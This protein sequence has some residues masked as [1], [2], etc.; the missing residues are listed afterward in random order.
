[1]KLD[2]QLFRNY[3]ELYTL[4]L[5]CYKDI[6]ILE[7]YERLQNKK[8]DLY[9]TAPHISN[10]FIV[11]LQKDLALTLWKIY[12]DTDTNA[13]TVPHFRNAINKLLRDSGCKEKQIK[14]GKINKGIVEV[15]KKLRCQFLAHVDMKRNDSKISIC[16]LKNLLNTIY[17]EFNKVCDIIDDERVAK[18][19]DIVIGVQEMNYYPELLLLYEQK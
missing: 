7:A 4:I 9:N 16:D 15:L 17:N 5:W 1:M 6:S 12:C 3:N 11:L 10:H 14:Q 18:I 19:S 8:K 2:K 13:N